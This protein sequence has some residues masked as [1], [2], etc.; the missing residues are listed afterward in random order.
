[1]VSSTCHVS[2]EGRTMEVSPQT[3]FLIGREGDL[4]LRS[5]PYLH[6]SFLE[7]ICVDDLWWLLNV[8][9]RLSATV[10]DGEG[11]L[12]AWLAPGGRIPL[13]FP[14]TTVLFTAGATP[15]EIVI[16]TGT[17]VFQA[18]GQRF[19]ASGSTTVGQVVLT[20]SQRALIT[21]VAEPLLRRDG[22]SLAEI[23]SS[24]AAARRLGW[25]QTRFNR[26]LD[27]VCDKLDQIGV[28]GLRGGVGGAAMQRRARL[29]EYAVGSRLV[30]PADLALLD[31]PPAA[32]DDSEE[33]A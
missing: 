30:T 31:A 6:R 25:T 2:S 29:A 17:P 5:N 4:A 9:T 28:A 33:S 27:N 16:R 18:S 24:A 10:T 13:L 21:A 12:H 14:V 19:E 3:P 7:I 23:P 1:M 11:G 26:K 32:G 20:S 15:Y 8:G 22:A